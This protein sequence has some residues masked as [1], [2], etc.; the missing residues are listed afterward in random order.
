MVAEA[1]KAFKPKVLC[2][3]HF[4]ETDTSELVKLL[5]A[6]PSIEVRIRKMK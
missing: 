3:Y 4:G 6:E 2:P 5:A 1:A